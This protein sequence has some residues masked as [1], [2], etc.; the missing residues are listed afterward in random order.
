MAQ[1]FADI[2]AY[3]AAQPAAAQR[4]L[5]AL[6]N[7][8]RAAV[9]AAAESISYGVPTFKYLGRPVVY[10]GAAKNHCAL[11]GM[12]AQFEAFKDELTAYQMAKGTLRFPVDQPLD[13]NL[14]QKL[15]AARIVEIEAAAN[16]PKSRRGKSG[17]T[18]ADR[19]P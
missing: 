6:R 8:I 3:L 13:E 15:L 12:S 17:P 4:T 18:A 1:P 5:T 7:T 9:P 11:Y 14:V 10:F 16:R 19:S 2:D